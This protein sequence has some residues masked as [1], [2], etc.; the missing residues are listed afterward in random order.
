M[1]P[2]IEFLKASGFTKRLIGL[3]FTSVVMVESPWHTRQSLLLGLDGGLRAKAMGAPQTRQRSPT[4]SSTAPALPIQEHGPDIRMECHLPCIPTPVPL[5]A[6]DEH[7][8]C[9]V[10]HEG[11]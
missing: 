10:S 1:L 11:E 9:A 7:P 5:L 6:E 2:W 8:G 3:L 4:S